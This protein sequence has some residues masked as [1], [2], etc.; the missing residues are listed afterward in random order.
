MD[1][2]EFFRA[3]LDDDERAA[4]AVEPAESAALTEWAQHP[5]VA[6]TE[7]SF[8]NR[9]D[10]VEEDQEGGWSITAGTYTATAEGRTQTHPWVVAGPGYSGGGVH[11]RETAEHIARQ[12]PARVL[13]DVAADRKLIAAFESSAEWYNRPEN[14]HHPAGEPHGLYTAVKIRAERFATHPDYREEWRPAED[15]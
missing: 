7:T 15:G 12:D 4:R 11:L 2:V 5:R 9:W 10:A 13:A 3:R 8:T 1:L 14:R 6:L